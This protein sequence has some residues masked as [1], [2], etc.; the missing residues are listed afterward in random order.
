MPTQGSLADRRRIVHYLEAVATVPFDGTIADLPT[1]ADDIVAVVGP[2]GVLVGS[3]DVHAVSLP[4]AT[5]V[6]DVM[7]PAPGTIRQEKS[8]DEVVQQLRDD[9]LGQ[10]FVTTIG[11]VLLGVVRTERLHA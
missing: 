1:D 2:P 10:V 9:G 6:A 3:V 11:G 7:E 4:A 8:V 5:A